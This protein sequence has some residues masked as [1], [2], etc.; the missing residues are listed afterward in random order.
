MNLNRIAELL[1]LA[2]RD[3]Q[4]VSAQHKWGSGDDAIAHWPESARSLVREIENCTELNLFNKQQT[5]WIGPQKYPASP[6]HL[7]EWLITKAG[8]HQTEGAAHAISCLKIYIESESFTFHHFLPLMNVE[9]ALT[10]T[11]FTFSNGVTLTSTGS[12]PNSKLAYELTRASAYPIPACETTVFKS[13]SSKKFHTADN[14]HDSGHD[15]T[16]SLS[17]SAQDIDDVILCLSLATEHDKGIFGMSLTLSPDEAVPCLETYRQWNILPIIR[18]LNT[19]ILQAD[20]L[21]RAQEILTSFSAAAP[22]MQHRFR[23]AMRHLNNFGAYIPPTERAINLRIALEAIFL[24]GDRTEMTRTM[25]IRAARLLGKTPGEKV[26]IKAAFN[27]YYSYTSTAVHTGKIKT[28]DFEKLHRAANHAKTAL[29]ECIQKK[30][31]PN[32]ELFDL[33]EDF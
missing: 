4:G 11:P 30:A 33:G 17:Q 25:S 31:Y 6:T 12:I 18:P 16:G 24:D 14:R 26:S 19:V 23:V 1:S 21:D 27:K 13:H 22:D 20:D 32:W 10:R 7:A 2:V 15:W 3:F 9:C 28:P 8:R 29:R 5:Q